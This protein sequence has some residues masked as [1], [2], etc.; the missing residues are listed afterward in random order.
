[1]DTENNILQ[2]SSYVG[3]GLFCINLIFNFFFIKK[4]LIT[5]SYNKTVDYETLNFE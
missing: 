4:I 2:Y 5:E 1:M 3:R